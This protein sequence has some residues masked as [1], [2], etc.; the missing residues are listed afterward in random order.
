VGVVVGQLD[1]ALAFLMEVVG[2]DVTDDRS[3]S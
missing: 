3:A 1:D 2:L